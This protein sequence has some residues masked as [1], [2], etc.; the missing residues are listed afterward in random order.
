MMPLSEKPLP[1]MGYVRD[2]EGKVNALRA[3]RR[4]FR[5]LSFFAGFAAGS[6]VSVTLCLL[7]R[8]LH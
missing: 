8:Y 3:D 7:L 6:A 5:Q 1:I 2:L 4:R